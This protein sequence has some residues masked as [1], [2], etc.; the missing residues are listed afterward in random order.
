MKTICEML[1][2]IIMFS[3]QVGEIGKIFEANISQIT[4]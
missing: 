2:K 1:F 4:P 3:G